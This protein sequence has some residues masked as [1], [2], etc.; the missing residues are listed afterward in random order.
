[1]ALDVRGVPEKRDGEQYII[2]VS[3]TGPGIPEDEAPYIFEKFYRAS[4]A[5]QTP[6]TGLGL[7]IARRIVEAHGGEMWFESTP[8]AGTTFYF[9]LPAHRP[10]T[11]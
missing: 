1:M 7:T 8:G 9:T 3:D 10:D 11:D 4:T 2:S 6:G 5:G